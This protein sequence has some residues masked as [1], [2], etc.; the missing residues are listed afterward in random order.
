MK[1]KPAGVAGGLETLSLAL[2]Y[3]RFC[4]HLASEPVDLRTESI[5]HTVGRKHKVRGL[6]A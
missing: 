4:A 3:Q 6:Q 5:F 1:K 2:I